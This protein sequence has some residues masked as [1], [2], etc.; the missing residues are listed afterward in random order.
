MEIVSSK[1]IKL[2]GRRTYPSAL[3]T[4]KSVKYK[5]K[6]INGYLLL[7]D[8]KENGVVPII[9]YNGKWREDVC[10]CLTAQD[11]LR[12]EQH[13]QKIGFLLSLLK[14]YIYKDSK[15]GTLARSFFLEI[16]H[17]ENGVIDYYELFRHNQDFFYDNYG[18]TYRYYDTCCEM[19]DTKEVFKALEQRASDENFT[20]NIT[21]K[22][23]E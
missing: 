10:Y 14:D 17:R 13:L 1:I 3:K 8:T 7:D 18:L 16:L 15:K 12:E 4:I 21:L 6:G 11:N 2:I 19:G 5:I 22:V 20:V 23:A 9:F